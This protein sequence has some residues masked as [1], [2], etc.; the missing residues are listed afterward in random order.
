MSRHFRRLMP[1]RL[2]ALIVAVG[3]LVPAAAVEAQQLLYVASQEEVTVAVIDMSS[4]ELVETV[5]LKA[6][7]YS[8]TAKAHHTACLLYTSPSPRD[9]TLSRMPSSA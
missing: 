3:T 4:N 7:G 9:A 5:D 2:T 1:H 6:L 8:E